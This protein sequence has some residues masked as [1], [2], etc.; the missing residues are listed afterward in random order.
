M[1]QPGLCILPGNLPLPT[2]VVES[3][4]SELWPRLVSDRD[5]WLIGGPAVEAVFLL[6]WTKIAGGRVK[7]DI[8][9]H[10]RDAARNVVLIQ[11]EVS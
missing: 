8:Q 2:V 3:G 11:E 10:G 7:G 5:L 4:W 9:L 1:K 6:R